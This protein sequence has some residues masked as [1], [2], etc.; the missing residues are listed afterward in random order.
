MFQPLGQLGDRL[1]HFPNF[2]LRQI[3]E[4]LIRQAPHFLLVA[5]F[6]VFFLQLGPDIAADHMREVLEALVNILRQLFYL[7]WT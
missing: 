3:V 5:Q 1:L 6:R 7:L 4:T 2:V